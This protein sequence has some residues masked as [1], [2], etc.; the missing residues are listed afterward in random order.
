MP[1]QIQIGAHTKQSPVIS[2]GHRLMSVE[3]FKLVLTLA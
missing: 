3:R 1:S 2:Q